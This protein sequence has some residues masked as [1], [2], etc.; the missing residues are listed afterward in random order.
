MFC[1]NAVDFGNVADWVAGFGA[2][3]A[4]IVALYIASNQSRTA[5]K[6]RTIETNEGYAKHARIVAEAIRLAAEVE[7][8][9]SA[10]S[11]LVAFGG[12]DS[13]SKK[14]EL[15]DEI[16]GIRTQIEALQRFPMADPRLFA[17]IGR[18]AHECRTERGLGEQSTS[19]TGL[20]MKRMAERVRTRREAIAALTSM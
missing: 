20:I 13:K 3:A 5:E 11:Q 12:G 4:V 7:T 15:L 9:A 8:H 17:E 2:L 1:P 6:L 18:I 10:Y 16:E 19:Y 14:S